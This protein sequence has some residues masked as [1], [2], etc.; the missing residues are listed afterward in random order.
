MKKMQMACIITGHPH[1]ALPRLIPYFASNEYLV[2]DPNIYYKNGDPGGS[3]YN[4]VVS[5]AKHFAKMPWVD[6]TK[7]AIQGQSWGGYQ[8]A[9]LVT[10]TKLFAAAWAGAPVANMTSAYGGIRWA[11]PE[12]SFQ[13]EDRRVALEQAFGN[14]PIYI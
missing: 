11:V 7:M 14:A 10:R 12:P 9:Y 6:S 5:A 2:F 3:A 8:V 4:S 13:Y 1:P